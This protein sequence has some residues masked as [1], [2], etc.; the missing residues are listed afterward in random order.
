MPIGRTTKA[1]P[2]AAVVH[3]VSGRLPTWETAVGRWRARSRN[4]NSCFVSTRCTAQP[5]GKVN[6]DGQHR[7]LKK[8]CNMLCVQHCDCCCLT[9]SRP[10]DAAL[11]K[12]GFV[13]PRTCSCGGRPVNSVTWWC[14]MWGIA[15]VHRASMATRCALFGFATVIP[16]GAAGSTVQG[17]ARRFR[18]RSAASAACS[19]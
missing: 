9:G 15:T 14:R 5:E 6:E 7:A 11:H 17:S 18:I 3:C 12:R 4:S 2:G 8:R 16:C 1:H 10:H 19:S 13:T